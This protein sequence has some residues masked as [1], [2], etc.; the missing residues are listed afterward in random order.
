MTRTR[1]LLWRIGQNFGISLNQRHATNAASELHLL[2]EAEEILG[3]LCWNDAEKIEELSV[4][5]WKL[6]TLTKKHDD[7]A[8][9][10]DSAND[11]LQKSHDQRS[12]LLGLVVDS[13]KE[14]VAERE[15]LNAK[16]ERLGS[17]REVILAD[18]RSVKRLHDGIKAKLDFLISE[19]GTHTPEVEESK[20][21]LLNLKRRFKSLR[22]QRDTLTVKIDNINKE[23]QDLDKRI[24]KRRG[25]MRDEAFG[26]YQN[27][28]QT[29]RDISS[30]RSEFGTLENE[31][32][33]LFAEIGRYI[34]ANHPHPTVAEIVSKNRSLVNQMAAL[35]ISINLNTQL[36]GREVPA[37]AASAPKG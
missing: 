32:V 36:S 37:L 11:S 17:E 22:E 29:N 19:S 31:M 13:T 18:A 6:R 1:Y 27:I 24:N 9:K 25:D 10:I 21:E 35:R 7:L 4:E 12:E 8:H 5:Y 34:I 20:K 14:L 23:I 2:R 33:L 16:S 15:T 26:S 28:G 3:R 30:T